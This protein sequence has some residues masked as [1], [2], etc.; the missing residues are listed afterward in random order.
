MM[1]VSSQSHFDTIQLSDLR[2]S[3][4]QDSEPNV[5]DNDGQETS[6][7][8]PTGVRSWLNIAAILLVVIVK[9]LV[10]PILDTNLRIG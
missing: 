8:Y 1:P 9:G 3:T 5:A 10:R 2:S 4:N 7:D 6:P